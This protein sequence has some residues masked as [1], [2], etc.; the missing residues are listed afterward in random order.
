[1]PTATT[2]V[3]GGVRTNR[4]AGHRRRRQSGVG[5]LRATPE[6]RYRA[7]AS[8]LSRP[9]AERGGVGRRHREAVIGP[10]SVALRLRGPM[11]AEPAR[12]PG[13]AR[14][15]KSGGPCCTACEPLRSHRI[16]P[17]PSDRWLTETAA[18]SRAGEGGDLRHLRA[19]CPAVR[20]TPGS[21]LRQC[22]ARGRAAAVDQ[23]LRGPLPRR[24]ACP[25]M[26]I[27]P[28]SIRFCPGVR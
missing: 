26:F 1:M 10:G 8:W 23:R 28:W 17:D 24:R 3:A 14:V 13:P 21:A 25:V 15:E 12:R 27:A 18:Q 7:W 19:P 20:R 4:R 5:A 6:S 16:I 22:S 9:A 11:P 2:A